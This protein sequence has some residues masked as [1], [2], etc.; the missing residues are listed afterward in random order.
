MVS[1]NERE[2]Y[3]LAL[4][5]TKG[6][7][8]SYDETRDT[9]LESRG[10]FRDLSERYLKYQAIKRTLRS[11]VEKGYLSKETS[12]VFKINPIMEAG[13]IRQFPI[14]VSE[15]IK[16]NLRFR[17]EHIL[18][19]DTSEIERMLLDEENIGEAFKHPPY[20]LIENMKEALKL[21]KIDSYDSVLVKCG[22]CVEIMV[23]E[24][25][26]DYSLFDK[27]LST[28]RIIT[29]LRN[30]DIF[31]KMKKN[32]DMDDFRTFVDGVN[33][34]YRFRNIMGAHQGWEWGIDQVATSC[35]ILTFYLA[36]LYMWNI[37]RDRT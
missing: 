16:S 9:I 3:C 30:E 33:V 22:K 31:N 5:I 27:E 14:L 15:A 1:L 11:L 21:Q 28:G 34:V 36:D 7:Q 18:E 8:A 6:G 10:S 2:K 12:E 29:R 4:I 17:K 32:V 35:L 26:D 19:F 37:R 20:D 24:L 25:D 13:F 23:N